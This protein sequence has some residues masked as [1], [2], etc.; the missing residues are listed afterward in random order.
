VTIEPLE[1]G[2]VPI[3]AIY[4]REVDRL[5]AG[6]PAELALYPP[7]SAGRDRE[8]LTALCRVVAEAGVDGALLSGLR[9]D[10]PEQVGTLRR[11]LSEWQS[12]AQG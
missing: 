9:P 10:D 2:E 4:A 7:I 1:R 11:S 8:R 5:V 3:L 12:P 6:A